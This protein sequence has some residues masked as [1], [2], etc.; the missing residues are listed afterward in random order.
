MLQEPEIT[1]VRLSFY[2]SLISGF[3]V[4]VGYLR[5]HYSALF[6]IGED[7]KRQSCEVFYPHII[8]VRKH[9]NDFCNFNFT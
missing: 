4:V 6:T 3:L 9:H 5:M 7:L 8:D 1:T 2:S